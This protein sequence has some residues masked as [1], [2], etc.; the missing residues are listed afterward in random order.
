V[1]ILLI[2]MNGLDD[3][4]GKNRKGGYIRRLFIILLHQDGRSEVLSRSTSMSMFLSPR[5][6]K[7]KDHFLT[8]CQKNL[9]L[10][11]AM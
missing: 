4:R 2:A 5:S 6:A 10:G 7:S 3:L 1:L 9:H 11:E 8:W